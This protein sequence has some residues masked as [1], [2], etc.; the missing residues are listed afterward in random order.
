MR[1]GNESLHPSN[2]YKFLTE[3]HPQKHE[4][5]GL[6]SKDEYEYFRRFQEYKEI[7]H[8]ERVI[9]ECARDVGMYGQLYFKFAKL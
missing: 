4:L 3:P 7:Q 2:V 9:H 8:I 6:V 1:L 5:Y